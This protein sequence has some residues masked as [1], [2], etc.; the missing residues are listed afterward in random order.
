M[1]RN[2]MRLH[3]SRGFLASIAGM[4][5]VGAPALAQLVDRTLA[6][7]TANEGIAKSYEEQIGTGRGDVLTPDSSL[8]IIG[9]DPARAIR[10]GRQIFQRKFTRVQGNGPLEGDGAGAIDDTL[11]IGAGLADSC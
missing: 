3:W 5:L 10:R 4:A 8:F 11:I 9:R 6:P 1:G 7:N 2:A